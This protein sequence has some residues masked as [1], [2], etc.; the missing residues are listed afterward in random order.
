MTMTLSVSTLAFD[1]GDET[2]A[3]NQSLWDILFH[4]DSSSG[5][6]TYIRSGEKV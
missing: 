6:G 2:C 5:N 1:V 3:R 4:L